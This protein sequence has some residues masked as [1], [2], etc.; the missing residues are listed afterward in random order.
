M[1]AIAISKFKARCLALLDAVKVSGKPLLITRHGKPVA[2]VIPVE[3]DAELSGSPI[4]CMAGT[5]RELADLVA[6]LDVN[7]SALSAAPDE[8]DAAS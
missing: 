8:L 2:R 3:G 4:G 1:Q 5:A 6:P 7:W